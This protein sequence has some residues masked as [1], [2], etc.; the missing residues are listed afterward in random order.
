MIIILFLI[1]LL[2]KCMYECM[3]CP[4]FTNDCDYTNLKKQILYK[5]T[6]SSNYL[7][8]SFNAMLYTKEKHNKLKINFILNEQQ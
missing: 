2:I 8:K 6:Y 1:L 4:Y 5:Q 7:V 3:E